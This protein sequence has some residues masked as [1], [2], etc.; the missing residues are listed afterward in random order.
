MKFIYAQD[1]ETSLQELC[2]A[3]DLNRTSVYHALNTLENEGFVIRNK[4]T[5]QYRPGP[6]IFNISIC[7]DAIAVNYFGAVAGVLER[8]VGEI[9][10]TTCV[11]VRKNFHAWCV[12][13]REGN[14]RLKASL[15][16][17]ETIPLH[18]TASGKAL[19]AHFAPEEIKKYLEEVGL[20][21]YQKNTITHEEKMQIELELIRRKG[22]AAEYE[23]YEELINAVAVPI[24]IKGKVNAVLVAIAPVVS[25]NEQNMEAVAHLLKERALEIR[26]L[27]T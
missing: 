25:L 9:N 3:L 4:E 27:L 6:E 1:H 20:K 17:G 16:R 13:G 19:L 23:E 7:K 22:Y 18:P 15:N 24:D 12:E 5:R 26:F 2:A 21:R 8:I 14:K 11:Y 10:E